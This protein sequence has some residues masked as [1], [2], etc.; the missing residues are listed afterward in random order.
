M[1]NNKHRQEACPV[2]DRECLERGGEE[3]CVAFM[4]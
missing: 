3:I 2:A 4:E 1:S